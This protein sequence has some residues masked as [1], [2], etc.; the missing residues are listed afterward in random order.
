[1]SGRWQEL[2]ADDLPLRTELV[3]WRKGDAGLVKAWIDRQGVLVQEWV[4]SRAHEYL[5]QFPQEKPARLWHEAALDLV[6]WQRGGLAVK[7]AL[8][9]LRT[10]EENLRNAQ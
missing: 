8:E 3:A 10:W 6:G 7:A 5:S 4:R 2:P 1:M 9:W